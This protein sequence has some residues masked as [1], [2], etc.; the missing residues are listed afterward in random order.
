MLLTKEVEV[1]WVNA[2]KSHYISKGYIFTKLNDTFMCN[3][4]DLSEQSAVLVNIKCDYCGKN[5]NKTYGRYVKGRKYIDKDACKS[6]SVR[7]AEELSLI[8]YGNANTYRFKNRKEISF[9]YCIGEH[10]CSEKQNFIIT[11]TFIKETFRKNGEARKYKY[12]NYTCLDCGWNNGTI[13]EG[14]LDAGYGCSCCNGRTVVVG[15]NDITTTA[16]WMI[17]FFQGGKEEA[18]KYT[19]SSNKKIYPKCPDCGR[20]KT[21][22]MTIN[23]INQKHSIGCYCSDGISY[24]EKFIYKLLIDN[25]IDFIKELSSSDLKWVGEYRY[26]FYLKKYN[27]IIEVHGMQHYKDCSGWNQNT[28]TLEEQQKIDEDKRTL[29]TN[30]H[31]SD[32]IILDCRYSEQ[33]CIINSIKKSNINKYIN[34]DNYD[35]T[36]CGKF[37]SGNLLKEICIYFDQNSELSTIDIS[38]IYKL[39]PNTVRKYLKEGTKLGFCNYNVKDAL[40]KSRKKESIRCPVKVFKDGILLGI[41]KSRANA[42][43]CSMELFGV[44]FNSSCICDVCNGRFEQHKGHYFENATIEEYEQFNNISTKTA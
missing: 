12:Y 7:K 24:P 26:D 8:Q 3:A 1:K 43:K 21:K 39:D 36:K 32:Y 23:S 16:P 35:F 2:T 42:A 20:V 44:K 10:I 5:H 41:F 34:L 4:C 25:N 28:N 15:I 30:N 27:V 14:N 31:V 9:K 22:L 17:P 40:E 6:C 18:S 19:C 29:A 37:A 13:E 38:K 33:E 11:D